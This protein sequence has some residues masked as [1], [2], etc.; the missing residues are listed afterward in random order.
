MLPQVRRQVAALRFGMPDVAPWGSCKSLHPR[1]TLSVYVMQTCMCVRAWLRDQKEV[2]Y[3]L[4]LACACGRVP[5]C[6]WW[7]G[8][9]ERFVHTNTEFSALHVSFLN[10]AGGG[11][12]A[13][14]CAFVWGCVHAWHAL[15]AEFRTV[16]HTCMHTLTHKHTHTHTHMCACVCA[17]ICVGAYV[18]AL[19]VC[20][21]LCVFVSIQLNLRAI[22]L[23][24][25]IFARRLTKSFPGENVKIIS[26]ALK[27][28]LFFDDLI[29]VMKNSKF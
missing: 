11:D 12:F 20:T 2:S 1:Y 13:R 14:T 5:P 18:C 9:Q 6:I 4:P 23:I 26:C 22:F 3:L 24:L 17:N 25:D 27:F 29:E 16:T 10:A 15:I 28:S 19:C 21:Y 8:S 7:G